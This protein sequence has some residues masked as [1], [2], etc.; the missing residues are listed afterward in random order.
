MREETKNL[1]Y[2]VI[3]WIVIIVM[4]A[5]ATLVGTIGNA[6][7]W[8]GTELFLVIWNAVNLFLG[9]ITGISNYTYKKNRNIE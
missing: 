5:V 9:T 3:K 1:I 7:E 6:V 4:P 8:S 2:D